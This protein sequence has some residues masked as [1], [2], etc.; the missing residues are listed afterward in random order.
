VI[1]KNQG[2]S[3]LTDEIINSEFQEV[4]CTAPHRRQGR[5]NS[6]N[7]CKVEN[8][9]FVQ[10]KLSGYFQGQLPHLGPDWGKKNQKL[11]EKQDKVRVVIEKGDTK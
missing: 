3:D 9:T 1:S 6:R 8:F 2:V 7:V 5:G 10:T 11:M 4:W